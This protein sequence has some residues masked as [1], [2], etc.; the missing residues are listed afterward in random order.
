MSTITLNSLLKKYSGG[1]GGSLFVGGIR[2]K[3]I[4]KHFSPENIHMWKIYLI[5]PFLAIPLKHSEKE[6]IQIKLLSSS[7]PVQKSKYRFDG[8]HMHPSMSQLITSLVYCHS[9]DY[10]PHK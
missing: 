5:D 9:G 2:T 4:F 3:M 6:I 10:P 8:P 7:N 1:E